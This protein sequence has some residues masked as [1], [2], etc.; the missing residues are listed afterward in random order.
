MGICPVV[1]SLK[2]M[3]S[4]KHLRKWMCLLAAAA[5][6]GNVTA[7]GNQ[8]EDVSKPD[9]TSATEQDD[10]E[11]ED[12]LNEPEEIGD[13][14]PIKEDELII[15]GEE[16][17]EATTATTEAQTETQTET[18]AA[19]QSSETQTTPVQNAATNP[20]E[21]QAPVQT[22]TPKETPA[23]ETTPAPTEAPVDPENIV[24]GI[25][26]LSKGTCEGEGISFSGNTLNIT[27][28]GTYVIS[29][30]LPD[31]MINVN[32]TLKVKLKLNGVNISN[33][34]GPAIMVTDAKRL[35]ITLIEGT[36]NTVSGGSVAN[37]GA[38]YT[39]DTLEIKGAGT[40][41]VNGTVEHGISSDDDV[42]IK[43]GNIH[44]NAVKTGVMANDDIT[45]SG[46]TLQVVGRTNG[47]KSKGTLHIAGGDI[48]VTGGPKETK[49]GLFSMTTFTLTGG[50][51]YVIGCDAAAPDAATSTQNSVTV[52]LSPSIAGGGSAVI[53][54]DGK[55]L[56]DARSDMAFNTVFVSTP[57]IRE[58]MGIHVSANGADCGNF[59]TTS[60]MTTIT[61]TY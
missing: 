20:P 51:L 41:H 42:V 43:N 27:G 22:E 3:R 32:T 61:A 26:D 15:K 34:A 7:C 50:N 53:S 59:T 6:L 5:M 16:T 40:L 46:G 9:T 25:A 49:S 45:I 29:G 33:S 21:T 31:G 38:I 54:T 58:G 52:R 60:N 14:A 35:T 12:Y 30:N 4:M 28:E 1:L 19:P 47:M 37:D 24:A 55:V 56:F 13:D 10:A 17:T 11:P 48:H 18:T 23:P 57:E 8:T 39:N 44:I 36:T 2:G